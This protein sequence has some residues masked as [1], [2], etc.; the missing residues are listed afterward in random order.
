MHYVTAKGILLAKNGMNIYRRL[1][2]MIAGNRGAVTAVSTL[3][4]ASK[5]LSAFG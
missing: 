1:R 2:F 3:L 4:Q 5:L